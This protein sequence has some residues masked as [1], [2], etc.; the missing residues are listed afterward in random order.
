MGTTDLFACKCSQ[1]PLVYSL[2]LGLGLLQLQQALRELP[3][4]EENNKYL[5]KP[6]WS[7]S[8]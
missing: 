1:H 3:G 7:G 2:S 4:G 5:A 6:F 8:V